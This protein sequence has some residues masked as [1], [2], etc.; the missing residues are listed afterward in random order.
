MTIVTLTE[1]ILSLGEKSVTFTVLFAIKQEPIVL[2]V[3]LRSFSS[4]GSEIT[5]VSV[6]A[7]ETDYGIVNWMVS[8]VLAEFCKEPDSRLI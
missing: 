6:R 1:T 7:C 3:S 2:Q 4:V 8:H 5:R